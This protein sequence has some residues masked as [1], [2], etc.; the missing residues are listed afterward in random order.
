MRFGFGDVAGS[1]CLVA[2]QVAHVL[3][4]RGWA[5]PFRRCSACPTRWP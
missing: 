1:P 3:G 2:A 4:Q 5:G